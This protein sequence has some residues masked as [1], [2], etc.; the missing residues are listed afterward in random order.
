MNSAYSLARRAASPQGALWLF[1]IIAVLFI[2]TASYGYVSTDVRSAFLPAWNLGQNHTINSDGY[3]NFGM[4]LRE[5]DGH[6]RSD[7]FPGVILAGVPSYAIYALFGGSPVP[8]VGPSAVTAALIAAGSVTVMHR[9]LLRL[10]TPGLALAGILVFALGTSTWT[11][12]GDALWTH[13]VTQF[14]LCLTLYGLASQRSLW[15]LVGMIVAVSSRPHIASVAVVLIGGLLLRGGPRR[16]ISAL[17]L[18]TGLGLMAIYTWTWLTLGQPTLLP[19]SYEGRGS[20]VA[21]AVGSGPGAVGALTDLLI[22][23]DGFLLSSQR[24]LLV[25]TPIITL[26]LI[27]F[28]RAWRWTQSWSQDAAIAATVYSLIQLSGNSFS[29][30]TA[31]YSYRLAIEAMTLIS[32]LVVVCAGIATARSRVW[33]T[34]AFLTISYGF[35]VH[36][37]GAIWYQNVNEQ[38]SP[39]N[40]FQPLDVASASSTS[41]VISLAIG[42]ALTVVTGTLVSS[43]R[44][45]ETSLARVFRRHAKVPSP[46]SRHAA[47]PRA[48]VPAG[49]TWPDAPPSRNWGPLQTIKRSP[50]S[51]VSPTACGLAAAFGAAGGL[52]RWLGPGPRTYPDSYWYVSKAF[53]WTG[54]SGST[55]SQAARDVVCS[56]R[57]DAALAARC[58]ELVADL[59]SL[60]ERY[61]A[62]FVSRPGSSALLTPFLSVFGPKA[63]PWLAIGL[64][65]LLAVLLSTM[66]I[67][68]LGLGES[69]CLRQ[70]ATAVT[71]SALSVAL[72]LG[73]WSTRVLS[74]G[75]SYVLLATA[76]LLACAVI[77]RQVSP[78]MGGLL[79][80]VCTLLTCA[81]KAPYG[82]VL[83]VGLTIVLAVLAV[84]ERGY[85]RAGLLGAAAGV[86]SAG[87]AWTALSLSLRWPGLTETLQEKFTAKFV[88]P[89]VPDPFTRL[90][91]LQ[92]ETLSEWFIPMSLRLTTL[93]V[94]G[95]LLAFL[96][97]RVRAQA[98]PW[99]VIGV[100]GPINVVVHPNMSEIPRLQATI[101]IPLTLAI[102][103]AILS[104]RCQSNHVNSA[105]ESSSAD[106]SCQHGQDDLPDKHLP[107]PLLH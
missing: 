76:A 22:K 83:A 33:R 90:F 94:V 99:L 77:G 95:G 100:I 3:L 96:A 62:I 43:D 78:T 36:A 45:Y 47:R 59:L 20:T 28:P 67:R 26:A 50:M 27:Q 48:L 106:S 21:A 57:N 71:T 72:P 25:L 17:A 91:G 39:W 16:A 46:S 6:V 24:G 52:A 29:G 103:L 70:G 64:A 88:R 63:L 15:V 101:W 41:V 34:A 68:W 60:P 97:Y 79:L 86:A 42:I 11:V 2:A 13:T 56:N 107:R 49:L 38:F 44:V 19:G 7:R 82:V 74:E 14:G 65:A 85:A 58:P 89:D 104:P 75:V 55:A 5:V 84:N 80:F 31:F 66:V 105:E 81:V 92:R 93:I 73:F 98:M 30:G 53:E 37:L 8:I 40:V 18:G 51:R 87:A 32:P 4:F 9:T 54:L 1:L 102:A 69:S 35:T 10:V 23:V 12:S 61:Q